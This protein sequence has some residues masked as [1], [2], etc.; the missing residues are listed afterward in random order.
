MPEM[1]AVRDELGMPYRVAAGAASP[2]GACRG[3]TAGHCRTGLDM[4][5]AWFGAVTSGVRAPRYKLTPVT[6]QRLPLGTTDA[7]V[8]AVGERLEFDRG[9]QSRPSSLLRRTATPLEALTLLPD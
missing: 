1:T 3:A 8:I 2:G 5:A 7:T 9:R 6:Y 4:A